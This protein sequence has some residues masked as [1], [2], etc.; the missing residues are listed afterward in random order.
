KS[1]PDPINR[2]AILST[3]TLS[4][5]KRTASPSAHVPSHLFLQ[6][7]GTTRIFEQKAWDLASA[8]HRATTQ[9]RRRCECPGATVPGLERARPPAAP[10]SLRPGSRDSADLQRLPDTSATPHRPSQ[11]IAI[12]G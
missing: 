8:D 11:R 1:F 12:Q 5:R 6:T 4:D 7:D 2:S 3:R 10:F 9:A